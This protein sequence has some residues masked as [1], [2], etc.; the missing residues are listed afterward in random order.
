MENDTLL[1]RDALVT[2]FVL[3]EATQTV[4]KARETLTQA[5][6][7]YCIVTS[8]AGTPLALAIAGALAAIPDP[9][10]LLQAVSSV[11]AFIVDAE[12]LLDQAVSFSAQTLVEHPEMAGLVVEGNDKVIGVLPRQAIR[13]HAQRI[14][15]RGG[16]ITEL[17]GIPLTRAK[18]FICPE[19]DYK[20]L[21]I[22]YDPDDPPRCPIHD[23]ALTKQE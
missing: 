8:A 23:L 4:A 19:G 22:R 3:L 6:A 17:A 21:V 1:V 15:T 18:Y 10:T 5:G 7:T 9:N 12:T 20:K 16:D 2:S 11:P 14:K 13:Q